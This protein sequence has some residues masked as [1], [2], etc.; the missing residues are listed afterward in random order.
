[1]DVPEKYNHR[2]SELIHDPAKL[3]LH[4]R[5]LKLCVCV[6]VSAPLQFYASLSADLS[7]L[8]AD[9]LNTA[10]VWAGDQA[11]LNPPAKLTLYNRLDQLQRKRR[12]KRQRQ[13]ETDLSGF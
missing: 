12:L 6:C 13:R 11:D 1:M 9:T 4:I 10:S 7:F 8:L 5:V 2:L 3:I